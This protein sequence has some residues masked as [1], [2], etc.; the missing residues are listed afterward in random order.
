MCMFVF[1]FLII[2]K[3]FQEIKN[4]NILIHINSL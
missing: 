4:R 2:D 3:L 1:I